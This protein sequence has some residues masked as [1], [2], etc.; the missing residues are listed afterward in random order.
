MMNTSRNLLLIALTVVAVFCPR[1]AS[2]NVIT[3]VGIA[4]GLTDWEVG[5]D[6]SPT[7]V[8]RHREAPDQ[9]LKSDFGDMSAPSSGSGGVGSSTL[10]ALEVPHQLPAS[11]LVRRLLGFGVLIFPDPPPLAMLRPPQ[12]HSATFV[13]G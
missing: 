5:A 6:P 9:R 12:T 11:P 1:T 10:V 8:D 7:D 13:V 3:D 2:A 4:F